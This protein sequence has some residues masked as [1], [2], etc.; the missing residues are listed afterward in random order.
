MDVEARPRSRLPE[1][2]LLGGVA[3]YQGCSG[4]PLV[5]AGRV[6]G[7]NSSTLVRGIGAAIPVETVQRTVQ[8]ILTQG[9]VRRGY[10]GVSTH[11][12]PLPA[13]LVQRL[14]LARE[15]GLLIVGVGEGS[16]AGRAG[17]ML[18]D[19]VLAVGGRRLRDGDDSQSLLGPE[20]I[21]KETQ[22]QLIRGGERRDLP[23]TIGERR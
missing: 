6:L 21:G 2:L 16:P 20:A 10:L 9:R 4:N 8:A 23:A 5:D 12:V 18:G 1:S 22:G 7:I 14:G 15:G 13:D 3:L 17:L 19:V 11:P